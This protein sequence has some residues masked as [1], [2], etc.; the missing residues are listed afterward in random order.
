MAMLKRDKSQTI[1]P[2]LLKRFRNKNVKIASFSLEMAGEAL[3]SG[4]LGDETNLRAIFK[5]VSGNA[6]HTNKEVRDAA[7]EVIRQI[8]RL[9]SDDIGVFTKHLT[10][11]RPIQL[12]EISDLLQE[13]ERQSS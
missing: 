12:K 1:N 3:R 8:Y 7:I 6:G 4:L 11:L 9:T 10:G 5:A 13:S 2:E